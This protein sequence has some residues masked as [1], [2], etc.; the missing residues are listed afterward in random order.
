MVCWSVLRQESDL[1]WLMMGGELKSR[2]FIHV[3]M[4]PRISV[5]FQIEFWLF[6]LVV[7]DLCWIGILDQ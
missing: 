6:E 2:F 5:V 1:F 4:E 3:E 7:M